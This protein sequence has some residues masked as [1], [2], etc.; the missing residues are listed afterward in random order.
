MRGL[1]AKRVLICGGTSGIGLAA[2]E[3][4]VAEGCSVV[5]GG[6]P[7]H[8]A[9][10]AATLEPLGASV[11][12]VDVMIRSPEVIARQR[13]DPHSMIH[14]VLEEGEVLYERRAA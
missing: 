8:T 5:A 3:R 6:L 7:S 14:R 9:D 11:L 12:P 1:A 2:A 10:A 4:F 13:N